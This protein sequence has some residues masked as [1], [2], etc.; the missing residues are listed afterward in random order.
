M[1]TFMFVIIWVWIAKDEKIYIISSMCDFQTIFQPLKNVLI[2]Y[3]SFFSPTKSKMALASYLRHADEAWNAYDGSILA[4][5]LSFQDNHV[6][7]PKLQVSPACFK[8]D[9]NYCICSVYLKLF[10]Y[11]RT[12]FKFNQVLVLALHYCEWWSDDYLKD[13]SFCVENI[14]LSVIVIFCLRMTI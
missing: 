6:K 3:Y 7:N 11:C 8:V 12:F 13:T 4:S 14:F 5:L 1:L 9:T 10:S 2:D